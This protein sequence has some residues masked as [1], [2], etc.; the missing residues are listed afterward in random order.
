MYII[1]VPIVA[2]RDYLEFAL[3]GVDLSH[4]A[5]KSMKAGYYGVSEYCG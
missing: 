2:S 3:N 5:N 1:T 4:M